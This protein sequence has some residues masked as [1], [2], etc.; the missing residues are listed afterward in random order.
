MSWGI[1][2]SQTGAVSSTSASSGTSGGGNASNVSGGYLY[3]DTST[4]GPD[5][6]GDFLINPVT[7][8]SSNC[9]CVVAIRLL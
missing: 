7:F 6:T 3:S 2:E 5:A 8:G 1:T 4:G 9:S